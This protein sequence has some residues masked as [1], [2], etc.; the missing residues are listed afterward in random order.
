MK[1][2]YWVAAIFATIFA[3]CTHGCISNEKKQS[4]K[5]IAQADEYTCSMHPQIVEDHPGNCP[6]CGMKLV[7][8][9]TRRVSTTN[10]D[11]GTLIQPTN[12]FVITSLPVTTPIEAKFSFQLKSYGTIETDTRAAG[13]ISSSVSGRI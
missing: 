3:L 1:R 6:I 11:L 10:L 2:I 12:D 13:S 9:S 7:K 5:A 8:K 4:E